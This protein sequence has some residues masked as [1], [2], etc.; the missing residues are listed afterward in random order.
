L[1]LDAEKS[2]PLCWRTEI[3]VAGRRDVIFSC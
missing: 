2:E 1:P 3:D